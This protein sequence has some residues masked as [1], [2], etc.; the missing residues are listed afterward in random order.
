MCPGVLRSHSGWALA[1]LAVSEGY[2]SNV[3]FT[4]CDTVLNM[5]NKIR[6]SYSGVFLI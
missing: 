6:L 1:L 5:L 4:D 3:S 2:S